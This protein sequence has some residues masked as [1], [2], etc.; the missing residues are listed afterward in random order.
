M[1]EVNILLKIIQ[2][3]ARKQTGGD[4]ASR[5]ERFVKDKIEQ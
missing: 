3:P 2:L 1:F 5:S 4:D